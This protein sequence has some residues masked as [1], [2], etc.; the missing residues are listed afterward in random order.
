MISLY[1]SLYLP[2]LTQSL[3][4]FLD[5]PLCAVLGPDGSVGQLHVEQRG[6]DEGEKGDGGAA[7][8][9]QDGPEAGHGLGDEQE[10][11]DAAG[12][13]HTPLPVKS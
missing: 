2:C 6:E 5:P 7:H 11:E 1:L 4:S 3:V 8:Q 13:E 9:V 10:D 12:P